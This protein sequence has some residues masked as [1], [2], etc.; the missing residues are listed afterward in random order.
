MSAK[1]GKVMLLRVSVEDVVC[2]G[3]CVK[4]A[5]VSTLLEETNDPVEV[6][7]VEDRVVETDFVAINSIVDAK[8]LDVFAA[9]IVKVEVDKSVVNVAVD[10]VDLVFGQPRFL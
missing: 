6:H 1:A 8:T 4:V 2:R 3:V 7:V 5:L 10:V 9:D